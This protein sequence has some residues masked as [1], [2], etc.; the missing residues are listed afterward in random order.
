MTREKKIHSKLRAKTQFL[1]S[2]V[3]IPVLVGCSS[4]S[5]TSLES[6]E[7]AQSKAAPYFSQLC[8]DWKSSGYVAGS[9][10]SREALVA[11]FS[12]QVASAVALDP[13]AAAPFQIAVNLMKN[14]TNLENQEAELAGNA[15]AAALDG[16]SEL[17]KFWNEKSSAVAAQ[18][19]A[20]KQKV[21]AKMNEACSL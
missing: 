9:I 18:A 5:E 7:P 1:L 20:E 8:A 15:F 12:T 17:E 6:Q 13:E 4:N 10:N 19:D 21:V 16:N 3:L 2:L 14:V 11:N